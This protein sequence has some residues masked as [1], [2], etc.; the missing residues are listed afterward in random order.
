[1]LRHRLLMALLLVLAFA[2]QLAAQS[3]IA[4]ADLWVQCKNQQDDKALSACT[5]I[6]D[7]K[8]ESGVRLA[9]A[10]NLRAV[11]HQRE[12][13]LDQAVADFSRGIQLMK[14][15]GQAGWELAF[16]YFMRANTYRA[17]GDLDQAIIDHTESISVAP[18]WDKS[19]NDR[20]AIYFQKGDFARALD[21]ISKVI[22]FRPNNPRVADSYAIR[23]MLLNR[24]GNSA[25]ALLDADR[26][27]ELARRSALALYV[28]ARIYEALGRNEE[29]AAGKRAA[30][31]I[32]ANVADEIEAMERVGK[33]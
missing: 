2:S 17:M 12:G 10:Y 30:L 24:M 14:D 3:P 4:N 8:T 1:M 23:A 28:R 6:I 20:G 19:Y 16:L 11:I 9:R 32:D 15:A 27:V 31:A 18:G 21:D 26:A 7:S 29:A 22:S 5:Q 13:Q 25:K 33:P